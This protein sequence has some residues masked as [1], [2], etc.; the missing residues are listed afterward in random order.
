MM[1]LTRRKSGPWSP[2]SCRQK[3][4]AQQ[5]EYPDPAELARTVAE[6]GALPPL[7]H[8]REIE[9]L[10]AGL[11]RA[12]EGECF[13]LQGGDCAESFSECGSDSIMARLTA[14]LQMSLI[15]RHGTGMPVLCL[16]RLAG[17]YAKPRSHPTET[18]DGVTLPAYRGDIINRSEFTAA[19]RVP[20][21][22]LLLRGYERSALTLNF[23]RTLAAS[24]FAD[25]RE[26]MDW[27]PHLAGSSVHLRE[28]TQILDVVRHELAV[29]DPNAG[30]IGLYTSHEMLALDYDLAQT[31]YVTGKG[32][33]NLTTHLPWIGVR[34]NAPDGAHV[35]YCRGIRNP[36]GIKVGPETTPECLTE[37]LAILH[38]DNEPGRLVLIHRFG[39]GRIAGCLASLIEAV[40]A[41]GKSVVWLSDPM[42]GNTETTESGVKTRRF[43]RILA[44]V[45]ES[46]RIHHELGS[47]LGGVH[48]EL[49]G[50]HVT[51]CI[52]GAT[53]L[54]AED[55]GRDYRSK[56]DPRLNYAQSLE[57][58]LEIALQ[59][60]RTTRNEDRPGG[61]RRASSAAVAFAR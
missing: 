41:T 49:T 1:L 9:A 20:D 3:V 29:P 15:L 21:P 12:A 52:G 36:I 32:W 14:L 35:E 51:E 10:K 18:R 6:L 42:H 46:I 23:V 39:A 60:N 37:L 47:V 7:V 25:L 59:V 16:G 11:A 13:V 4:A 26:I 8:D 53:R 30:R 54:T 61:L 50:E 17:Q 57:L 28:L 24:N 43:E 2:E 22:S 44:E 31:R 33:Y 5:A 19:A 34:T 55:L 45:S 48:L 56:V 27:Q 58:A 38:P 40:R